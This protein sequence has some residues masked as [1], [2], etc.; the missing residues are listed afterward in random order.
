M[1]PSGF[2]GHYFFGSEE[3]KKKVMEARAGQ[4]LELVPDQPKECFRLEHNKVRFPFISYFGDHEGKHIVLSLDDENKTIADYANDRLTVTYIPEKECFQSD[5]RSF[6]DFINFLG[7]S[8]EILKDF[9]RTDHNLA[10]K[11][12]AIPQELWVILEFAFYQQVR[13]STDEFRLS[14]SIPE[15][16]DGP[17]MVAL[18]LS[19]REGNEYP[20]NFVGFLDVETH[21]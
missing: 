3:N 15:T 2:L 8:M 13:Q 17:S 7:N 20:V 6:E 21:A 4:L 16:I 10:F 18:C 9:L 1:L 5:L 19:L 12:E 14:V 11:H